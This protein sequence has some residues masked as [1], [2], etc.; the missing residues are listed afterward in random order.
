M[1]LGEY[2]NTVD[3]KGRIIIPSRFREELGHRFILTKGL[4]HCLIIYSMEEWK[5]FEDKLKS[6]PIASKE[7]RSFVRYFFSGA[8]E[9]EADKQGRMNIPPH[10]REYARIE[11]DLVTIGVSDRVEIWSRQEWEAYQDSEAMGNDDI[12]DKMAQFGI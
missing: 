10:L 1:L 7:A 2:Q 3:N 5:R 8:V 11:K 4:D 12:A 6:L 9:C